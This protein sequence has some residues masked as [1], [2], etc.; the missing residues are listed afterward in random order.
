MWPLQ[1]EPAP[2]PEG[3]PRVE[4]SLRAESGAAAVT[5]PTGAE[6]PMHWPGER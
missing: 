6:E 3:A 5:S 2:K 1:P 4:P